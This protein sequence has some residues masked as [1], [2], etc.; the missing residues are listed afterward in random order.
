MTDDSKDIIEQ[1]LNKAINFLGQNKF[2]DAESICNEIV[3]EN[4]NS[5]AY[6][7]LSS[8]KLYQ[9]KF[10]E[11]INLVNK[12]IEINNENPGY[13]V[14]LGC[15]F[16]ASKDYVNSITAFKKSINLNDKT[17]Q[18][19]F[20][21]GES[22]RKLKKYNDA[23]AS[24][25]RSIELSPDHVAA[26]MLLGL[27]YQEKKQFD[28]SIQSFKKCIEIM[29]DYAEAHLNLGLCYL[30]IGDYE[31]GW[32][33]YEWRKKLIKVPNAN[34]NKE[35]TGQSLDNKT[36]LI[37]EEGNE[38]LIQFVRFAKE[39]HKDNCKIILQCSDSS[40]ELMGRQKWINE[41]VAADNFPEHDYHVH[42]GSLM[43]VLQCNPNNLAHEFPYIESSN[44]EENSIEKE[45]L[46]IGVVLETNRN[47]NAHDDESIPAD[48]I[49]NIFNETHNIICLDEYIKKENLPSI[50]NKIFDYTNLDELSG[51][52]SNLD[53]VITVDHIVAHV[54][55]ALNINTILMLPCVP[56]WRWEITHR[57]TTPWYKS[58][59]ILRQETPGNWESVVKKVKEKIKRNSYV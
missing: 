14:T 25:Y 6:H 22:Y 31:N 36:L 5:D 58:V 37:L 8:I 38:N 13:Y 52:I 3:K 32:R 48:K 7:I 26:Y 40:M 46:N 33:E 9:Q 54:A 19:H 27:V 45:K 21:L 28:L 47:S 59:T 17:A 23:I 57:R 30:L 12:S 24:F 51:L 41:V 2:S 50:Y 55:G 11:S 35:W 44:N 1:E 4:E 53:L 16:S 15:A 39:L 29:P 20:Y 49:S 10:H 34:L 42:I 56:N 18:V 43:K